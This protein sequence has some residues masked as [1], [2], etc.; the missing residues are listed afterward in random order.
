[1]SSTVTLCKYTN[2]HNKNTT[3]NVL[4]CYLVVYIMLTEQSEREMHEAKLAG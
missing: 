3:I 1:M 2:V 4:N